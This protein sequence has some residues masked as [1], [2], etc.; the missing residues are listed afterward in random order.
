MVE[1]C[2][3]KKILKLV[4]SYINRFILCIRKKAHVVNS[5]LVLVNIF[6][7][8]KS[9]I[10]EFINSSVMKTHVNI[11]GRNNNIIIKGNHK[12]LNINIFGDNNKL[13]LGFETKSINGEIIVRG[14]DCLLSIGN[15]TTFGK[16]AYIVCM[17]E[18]NKILIGKENMFADNIE[19]WNTDSHPIYDLSGTLLNPSKPIVIGNHN[20]IGKNVCILKG[21]VISDNVVIGMASMIS[22]QKIYPNTL[23][24]GSPIRCI[25]NNINWERN[26]IQK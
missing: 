6:S 17:G 14:H 1:S 9:N 21:S 4:L 7:K 10:I 8:D 24:V 2:M 25:K 3:L 13:E 15:K 5:E 19:I 12:N 22:G 18:S 26:F 20:W 11:I 16:R 23:N